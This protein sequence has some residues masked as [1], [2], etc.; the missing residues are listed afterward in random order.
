MRCRQCRWPMSIWMLDLGSFLCEKCRRINKK[1]PGVERGIAVREALFAHAADMLNRRRP[2]ESVESKLLAT[3]LDAQ[4]ASA[5]V[6]DFVAR[7]APYDRAAELLESGAAPEQVHQELV[8]S[9]LDDQTAATVVHYSVQFREHAHRERESAPA[10]ITLSV[11]GVLLL[12]AGVV[13]FVGN[14][15]GAMPTFPFAGFIVMG[16]GGALVAAAERV[17]RTA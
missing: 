17:G 6:N 5:F 8:K 15:T 3:G 10:R 1:M 9:G 4:T 7:R 16:V 13:L 12:L 2:P 14:R 11:I